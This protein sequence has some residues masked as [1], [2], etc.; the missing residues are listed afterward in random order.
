[1]NSTFTGL[2]IATRG[3]YASSA[4]LLVTNNNLSNA[5]TD[6]Y[7]RQEINQSTVTPAAVYNNSYILGAGATVNS[8]DRV[9]NFRLDQKY[10]QEN[11]TLSE[12]QTKSDMLTEVQTVFGET[13]DAAFTTVM[14]DFNDALEDM[15]TDPSS[16]S[17]RIALQQA[18][19]SLC[20]YLN[21][22]AED[23]TQL[24]ENVNGEIKVTVEQINSH[25]AQIAALNE[26][27]RVASASSASTNDLE[28]QRTLLI[29]ELSGLVGI[30]VTQTTVGKLA[31][32]ND[33]IVLSITVNGA[34]LV[35]NN[36]AQQLECYEIT[37]SSSAQ[38]GLYGIRWKDTQDAFEPEG[39][40]LQA[41]LDLRDGTGLNS[42]YKGIPYYLEQFDTFAQTL[43][44]AFN[45]VHA[46]GYGLEDSTD[47]GFFAYLD[48]NG[49]A[50]SGSSLT[51]YTKIT[52]ANISLSKE[53]L[54]DT[55]T[56]AASSS[57]GSGVENAEN[58][59]DL[60]ELMADTTMFNPGT[61]QEFMNSI[62]AT[63][64]TIGEYTETI[65]SRQSTFVNNI[66][67]RRT[68]ISGVSTNEETANLTKYEEAYNASAQMMTTW[69]KIYETTI[70]MVSE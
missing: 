65:A 47:I 25:A 15:S 12:L 48:S 1:M 43:A 33:D 68:S 10:W 11:S 32:G 46:A 16:S 5:N 9:R 58:I 26:K 59:S 39:G 49:A 17:T 45:N 20:E 14:N 35:N 8:V 40:E 64:G 54:A 24:R 3:L 42:E 28:D 36:E 67:T 52:A 21:T 22:C 41:Y 29:D 70:N 56:I 50:I 23:L 2:S 7:S 69:S 51:D 60:I 37:D 30:N 34:T 18:G 31:N 19:V 66:D 6:G 57:K 13:E 55:D 61:P 38:Y 63:I 44:Q 53:V 4:A 62:I 27:I